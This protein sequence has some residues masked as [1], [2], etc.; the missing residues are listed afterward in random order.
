MSGEGGKALG[1][2]RKKEKRREPGKWEDAKGLW[3][4]KSLMHAVTLVLCT[5]FIK[6]IQEV[7]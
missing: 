1:G 3:S 7:T 4:S 2:E 5:S 6:E